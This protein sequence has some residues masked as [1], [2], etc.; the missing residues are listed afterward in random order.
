MFKNTFYRI[1]DLVKAIDKNKKIKI[2]GI[3]PEKLH[4]EMIT[5]H[6]H[7]TQLKNY[8]IINPKKNS[9]YDSKIF[10]ITVLIIAII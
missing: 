8:F 6:D 1:L 5:V 4:E 2:I 10:L 7:F 9:N 3:R